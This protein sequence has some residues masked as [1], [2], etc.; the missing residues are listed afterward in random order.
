MVMVFWSDLGWL[1]HKVVQLIRLHIREFIVRQNKLCA[2]WSIRR[3][4]FGLLAVLIMN[5]IIY[6]V[7]VSADSVVVRIVVSWVV[8]V[9]FDLQGCWGGD[10]NYFEELY[11]RQMEGT[12][13]V[14]DHSHKLSLVILV[15]DP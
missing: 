14:F 5:V 12:Y 8:V 11:E 15:R 10:K 13:D 1:V 3:I 7:V 9:S 6:V 2:N 4:I